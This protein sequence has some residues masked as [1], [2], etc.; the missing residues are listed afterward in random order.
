[1]IFWLTVL[2]SSAFS[3]LTDITDVLGVFTFDDD[4]VDDNHIVAST[5]VAP[6]LMGEQLSVTPDPVVLKYRPSFRQLV[7]TVVS[8]RESISNLS[9]SFESES[10]SESERA[11][12]L[13]KNLVDMVVEPMETLLLSLD[14][15]IKHSDETVVKHVSDIL[16]LGVLRSAVHDLSGAVRSNEPETIITEW[17]VI[18]DTYDGL[19]RDLDFKLRNHF[20]QQPSEGCCQTCTCSCS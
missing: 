11:A 8:I 17:P 5:A 14:A 6:V 1:M 9:A 20:D 19:L 16:V 7:E 4:I 15:A 3:S 2:V 10:I 12:T 13:K 18:R